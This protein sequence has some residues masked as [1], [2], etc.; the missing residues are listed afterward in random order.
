MLAVYLIPHSMMGSEIDYREM[1]RLK[2]Q[3]DSIAVESALTTEAA[4]E[5]GSVLRSSD[6]PAVPGDENV[7]TAA[8][9]PDSGDAP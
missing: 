2:K 3:A 1:D 4:V 6:D 8:D 5:D 7:A 9:E